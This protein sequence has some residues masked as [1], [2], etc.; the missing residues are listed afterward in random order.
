MW[1]YL[2]TIAFISISCAE[3]SRTMADAGS[4]QFVDLP[5]GR[6]VDA[7]HPAP[8]WVDALAGEPR[9]SATVKFKQLGLDQQIEFAV[10]MAHDQHP[11]DMRWSYL[12]ANE[13]GK[14]VPALEKAIEREPS[15]EFALG[16]IEIVHIIA[17]QYGLAEYPTVYRT[18]R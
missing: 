11:P 8:P 16:V 7:N 5:P 15:D 14:I 13:G 18:M 6:Y 1:M 4:R 3:G 9:A 12:L 17:R 2:L 10:F